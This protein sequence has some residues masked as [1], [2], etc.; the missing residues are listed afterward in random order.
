MIIKG[1]IPAYGGGS[2]SGDRVWLAETADRTFGGH[3]HTFFHS[4]DS[5]FFIGFSVYYTNGAFLWPGGAALKL[6]ILRN[7]QKGTSM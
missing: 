6:R 7:E 3:N 4:F 1:V 5:N 2:L